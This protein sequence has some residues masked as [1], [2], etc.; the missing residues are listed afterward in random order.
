[1]R[2]AW[3]LFPFAFRSQPINRPILWTIDTHHYKNEMFACWSMLADYSSVLIVA[4]SF[5]YVLC[6]KYIL[7]DVTTWFINGRVGMYV[8]WNMGYILRAFLFSV[9][10]VMYMCSPSST[11]QVRQ[12]R[13]SMRT[14]SKRRGVLSVWLCA[15]TTW[16]LV[17][18]ETHTLS[19]QPVD[20]RHAEI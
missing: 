2:L 13:K 11:Y 4:I 6:R 18:G 5:I 7:E 20:S 16:E 10:T 19:H 1:M 8:R 12:G 15:T 3:I 9:I 17:G 14:S